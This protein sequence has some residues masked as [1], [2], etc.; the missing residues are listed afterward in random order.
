MYWKPAY[1]GHCTLINVLKSHSKASLFRQALLKIIG[2]FPFY[3][4]SHNYI[5]SCL[6]NSSSRGPFLES[7]DNLPGPISIFSKLLEFSCVQT[8]L[9]WSKQGLEKLN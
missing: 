1:T 5:L 2:F 6:R 8:C 9:M 3:I 7:T 4:T